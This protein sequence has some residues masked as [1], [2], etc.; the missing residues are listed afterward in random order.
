MIS[1]FQNQEK[2]KEI[3]KEMPA[4]TLASLTGTLGGVLNLW[5]GITFFTII[6]LVD[7][8]F[9]LVLDVWV[10]RGSKDAK[11]ALEKNKVHPLGDQYQTVFK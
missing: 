9:T 10:K 3:Y 8:M 7:L 1:F 2:K 5:I 6:E 11:P 4:L